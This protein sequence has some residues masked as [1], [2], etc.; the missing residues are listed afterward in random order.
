MCNKRW[1]ET[2]YG[3]KEDKTTAAYWCLQTD[4]MYKEYLEENGIE[5][6]T[7]KVRLA[8]GDSDVP[9]KKVL[10]VEQEDIILEMEAVYQYFDKEGNLIVELYRV[11]E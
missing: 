11:T 6:A 4:P 10:V 1:N 9:L 5:T 3:E 7:A 2:R 8:A